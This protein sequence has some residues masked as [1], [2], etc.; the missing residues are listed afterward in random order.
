[1]HECL[2]WQ[3]Q[4]GLCPVPKMFH[5]EKQGRQHERDCSC[6][7]HGEFLKDRP[8]YSA[9]DQLLSKG[10]QDDDIEHLERCASPP[11]DLRDG[12]VPDIDR[13]QDKNNHTPR[14]NDC[15]PERSGGEK[16]DTLCPRIPQINAE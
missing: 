13:E 5:A 11:S 7:V 10:H 4:T 9:K 3:R 15:S 6:V 2:G 12:G 1:M 16:E 8:E 14:V